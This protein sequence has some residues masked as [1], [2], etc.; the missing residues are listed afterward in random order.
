MLS[1][2]VWSLCLILVGQVQATRPAHLL[3]QFPNTTRIDIENIA[4]RRNGRLLLNLISEPSIYWLDPAQ[5][6]PSPKHLHTFPYATSLTGI[7]ETSPDVFAVAV[8][9]Y[10][11]QKLQAHPGSFSIWSIDLNPATPVAKMITSIPEAKA[12]NG[13]TALPG[14][15]DVVLVAD[16]TLGAIFSVNITSGEH[17][18][19][20][21]DSH[22]GRTSKFP[23]GIN[24]VHARGERLYF[25]NSAYATFGFVPVT[26]EGRVAGNVSILANNTKGDVYDDFA[27]DRNGT[28]WITNHPNTLTE[29]TARGE[30]LI[31]AG[32]GNTTQLVQPTSAALGRGDEEC[33]LYIVTAGTVSK[34][35]DTT[36][37]QVFTINIC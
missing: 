3:Y 13:M 11:Y 19:A 12:L 30:Q 18:I 2:L 20:I 34:N 23:I 37:G 28:A 31:A 22:F 9:N 27:L 15:P 4:I 5:H 8:G 1:S 35:S 10:T 26:E 6:N 7:A 17:L 16:S 29:V 33:T 24:G 21:Q 25:T 36:C 14:S 32:G